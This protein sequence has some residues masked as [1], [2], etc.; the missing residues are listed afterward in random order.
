MRV[1][2]VKYVLLAVML[3]LAGVGFT[4]ELTMALSEQSEAEL[5]FTFAPSLTLQVSDSDIIID[6][7]MPGTSGLSN[8]VDVTVTTNAIYGYVLSAT[9]GNTT[10]PTRNLVRDNNNY[11][12][13]IVVGAT[14]STLTN[15]TWGYTLDNGATFSG[16]PLYTDASVQLNSSFGPVDA[17]TGK[18]SFAIGAKASTN[19][20]SGN[21]NNVVNFTAVAKA[22][23]PTMQSITTATCPTTRI[24]ASDVRD[25][26]TY[27]IQKITTGNT[28]LCWMTSNLNIAGGTTL[29]PT[30]SNVASNYILPASST[31]GFSDDN[32][33]SVYNDNTYGGY[34]NY[35]AATVGTNPGSGESTYDIC[36]KGWHLPSKTNFDALKSTYATAGTVV[37]APW[38]GTYGGLYYLGSARNVG[39]LGDYWSSTAGGS[40]LAYHLYFFSNESLTI[41]NDGKDRGRSVRCVAD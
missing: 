2:R 21:Y 14:T 7:L 28:T 20:A 8:T 5:E 23:L 30:T 40:S 33:A 11:L 9:T 6:N 13:S 37:A 16:L 10:Y 27:Y 29:T 3:I 36:P 39:S 24:L 32:I 15:D 38:Y 12:G 31:A 4:G 18:T 19:K 35:M 17:I 26:Q 34:Y 41:N 25:G 22:A 1:K